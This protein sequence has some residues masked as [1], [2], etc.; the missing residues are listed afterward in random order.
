MIEFRDATERAELHPES[1]IVLYGPPWGYR[2]NS[3]KD[4]AYA[5]VHQLEK[6]E[7]AVRLSPGAALDTD[8]LRALF[9]R[10]AGATE[11]I[12]V[13]PERVLAHDRRYVAWWCPPASRAIFFAAESAVGERAG[14]VPQPG[15]VF[16]A[17][18]SRVWVMALQGSERPRATTPLFLSPYWN[19][20]PRGW[21]CQGNAPFPKQPR[22]DLLD[23]YEAAFFESRNTHANV[24][25]NLVKYRG[26]STALWRHLL[27]GRLK[28]FPDACLTGTGATLQQ[29]LQQVL[30]REGV[31]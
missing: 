26:G 23:A 29:W 21:V 27:S 13:L 4:L 16:A 25:G 6:S 15:L 11:D 9:S 24:Q 18:E 19:V 20:D 28:R 10:L 5:T 22:V 7:Q 2:G 14:V 30:S 3:R 12:T 8:S 31:T 17:T 1:V